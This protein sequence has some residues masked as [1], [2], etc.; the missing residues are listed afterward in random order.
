[1]D[2]LQKYLNNNKC[3]NNI[4]RLTQLLPKELNNS[5]SKILLITQLNP[6]T[7]KALIEV[8]LDLTM[9]TNSNP[10]DDEIIKIIKDSGIKTALDKLRSLRF[11]EINNINKALN[12]QIS[13]LPTEKIKIK[14]DPDLEEENLELIAKISSRE[15]LVSVQKEISTI[16]EENGIDKIFKTY[17]GSK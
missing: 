8:S 13:K 4:K 14:F 5:I 9:R 2:E 1:M 16:L 11:S 6:N 7:L 3:S 10:I 15:D 12:E 17:N